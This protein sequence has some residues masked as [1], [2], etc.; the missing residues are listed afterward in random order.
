M[1]Q[2]SYMPK[3]LYP[4]LVLFEALAQF[5]SQHERRPPS[6][7]RVTEARRKFLDSF[8]YI[9]DVEKGGPTVTAAAIQELPMSNILWLA[10]NE[11]IRKDIKVYAEK[12][13]S[14]LESSLVAKYETAIQEAFQTVVDKCHS[15]ITFYREETQ[16]HATI[17]RMQ[18]RKKE[19]TEM[20]IS[21][22]AF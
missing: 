13:L 15:R 21:F 14:L 17:C 3:E 20:G 1:S 4:R 19:Q 16:K 6:C 18:L 7:D 2:Q 5:K 12:I 9:C 11:G 10:A 22:P 8:A